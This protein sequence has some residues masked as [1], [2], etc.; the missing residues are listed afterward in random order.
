MAGFCYPDVMQKVIA[1][2]CFISKD[3]KLLLGMKKRGFGLGK[4]NGFGGKVEN[5]ESLEDSAKREIF[6]ETGLRALQL[7]LAGVIDFE[8]LGKDKKVQVSFFKVTEFEGR[9]VETE[10]MRPQWFGVT[11]IPIKDMW[12]DD[13]Y[14][15]PLLLAGKKFKGEFVYEGY[16]KIISH[17]LDI[18][19][20]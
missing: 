1:T 10:E 3:A 11:G 8:Y 18:L 13:E 19:Q 2:N 4:W 7:E 6:E 20:D 12:P 5:G 14:W 15:L 17:K 16:E 9:P